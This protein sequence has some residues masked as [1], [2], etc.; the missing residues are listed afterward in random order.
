MNAL[1][2]Y[3][4][5]TALLLFGCAT[6]SDTLLEYQEQQISQGHYFLAASNAPPGSFYELGIYVITA[7]DT[8]EK[9]ASKFHVSA[10][11]ILTLNPGL[12]PHRLYIGQKIR[13]YEK[14]KE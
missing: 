1:T 11:E 6:D 13:I 5:G 2:A 7:G 3:I 12:H 10:D 9:I 4:A 14:K 8:V